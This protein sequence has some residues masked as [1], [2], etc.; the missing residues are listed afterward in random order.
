MRGDSN[1]EQ[2][3][4]D[5]VDFRISFL[6]FIGS[7]ETLVFCSLKNGTLRKTKH[8]RDLKKLCIFVL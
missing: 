5:C 4:C 1:F 6:K 7:R 3:S 2:A 8:T